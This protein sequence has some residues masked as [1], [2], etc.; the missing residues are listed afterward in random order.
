METNTALSRRH[1]GP[2]LLF[3]AIVHILLFVASLVSLRLLEHTASVGALNPYGPPEI[4]RSFFAANPQAMRVDA[5]F[6]FG[7]AIPLAIYAATV[8]SRLRFLGVRAAGIYIAFAG[9]LATSFAIA[10]A[11]LCSWALS[12]PEATASIAVTRV[13]HFM[14]FLCGGPAFAAGFG[15]LAAGVSVTSYFS[16]LLPRWVVWLGMVVA[17]A[18][19]L[20]TLTLVATPMTF[21]I[22]VTRFGGFIWLIAVGATLPNRVTERSA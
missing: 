3:L 12:L 19:E 10:A 15:L 16:R 20:S 2:S 6:F 11:G 17:V 8:L 22:P 21:A 5:F 4:A 1:P 7:S 14:T 13:L 18:G 9:G